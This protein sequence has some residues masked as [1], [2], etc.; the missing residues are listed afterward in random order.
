MRSASIHRQER[1]VHGA[2]VAEAGVD[3]VRAC[4]FEQR[5]GGERRRVARAAV[6]EVLDEVGDPGVAVRL[7]AMADVVDHHHRHPRLPA[8]L[9]QDDLEAVR[10][11]VALGASDGQLGRSFG[12]VRERD[13]EEECE[14]GAQCGRED[15][16][17]SSAK[18]AG[19]SEAGSRR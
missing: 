12:V 7:V 5:H 10:Q 11:A 8:I 13:Y 17:H 14:N 6:G 9:L 15:S 1:V 2:V 18:R 19:W 16:T 4:R 3:L